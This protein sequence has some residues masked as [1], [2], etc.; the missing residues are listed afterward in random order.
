MKKIGGTTYYNVSDIAATLGTYPQ[1][2]RWW[3]WRN[4]CPAP[5][6]QMGARRY[7]TE[8]VFN[9]AVRICRHGKGV[10]A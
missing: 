7:Y 1:L 4:R 5:S 2:V 8:E 3:I 9:E 6:V 10:R